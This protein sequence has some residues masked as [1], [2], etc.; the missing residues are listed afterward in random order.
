MISFILLISSVVVGSVPLA[1]TTSQLL[2]KQAQIIKKDLK[3]SLSSCRNWNW[4][5]SETVQE[6]MHESRPANREI[7]V[8][9]IV[10]LAVSFGHV[11][12]L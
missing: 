5:Y 2:P 9:T 11:V 12:F 1:P 4:K 10:S 3:L 8:F 6:V 7:K